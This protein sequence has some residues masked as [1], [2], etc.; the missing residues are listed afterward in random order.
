MRDSRHDAVGTEPGLELGRRSLSD[1]PAGIH[2]RDAG[3]ELVGLVEVLRGHEHGGSGGSGSAH[4][5]PDLVAPAG[6]ESGGR[7][8]QEEHGRQQ[9]EAGG[10][11]E[12]ATHAARESAD[13]SVRRIDEVEGL[14][15]FV[16]TRSRVTDPEA[17][18][19]A[20]HDEVLAAA[21]DL[22]DRVTL[23]DHPD[24]GANSRGV[25]A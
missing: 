7:F 2:D 24:P 13:G 10:D 25:R 5:R 15:Q 4:G 23:A 16:G 12:T 21:E 14:E 3:G 22:V 8:V 6:V 17:G 1:D 9:D 20:E 18:E 11:V 19:A